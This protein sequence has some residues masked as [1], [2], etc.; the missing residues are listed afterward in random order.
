[1]TTIDA[2]EAAQAAAVAH[3]DACWEAYEEQEKSIRDDDDV[4]D[5]PSPAVGG[6]CGCRDCEVREVLAAAWPHLLRHAADL[7][8]PTTAYYG[9]ALLLR[10]EADRAE[11][12]P[13]Q[14]P[15]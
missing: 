2:G 1:M 8:E 3:L 9:A 13:Q 6:F 5:V 12:R 7:I 4:A 15:S 14:A 10:E 11:P